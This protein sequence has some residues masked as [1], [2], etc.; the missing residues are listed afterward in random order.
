MRQ[1][2]TFAA[3]L[4]LA[5]AACTATT[6]APTPAPAAAA[7]TTP[8]AIIL[9][10]EWG[11]PHV[12]AEDEEALFFAYGWAQAHN[13]AEL[14]VE[15]LGRARARG[16]EVWGEEA[17]EDDVWYRTLGLPEWTRRSYA[18]LEPAMRRAVD[19]F[20]AGVNAYL[21]ENP[22]ALSPATAAVLPVSGEDVIA[23]LGA[24]R[25]RFSQARADAE[26]W[27]RRAEEGA[28]LP[29]AAE[30]ALASNAWALGPA[31]STSGNALLLANPHLPW[32][33]NL[34]W[35]EA[36]L[37][38]PGVDVYGA[39]LVGMPVIAIG[40]NRHL[41]WT[42]TV[43]TQDVED[44][45]RLDL[46]DGGY[47]FGGGVRPFERRVETVRVKTDDGFRDEEVEVLSSQHGPV[48]ATAGQEALALRRID[49]IADLGAALGQ[50]WAMGKAESFDDFAAALETH[51]IAGQNVTYADADGR[52]AY[53]YG[54]VL[55]RRPSGDADFWAGAVV[56]DEPELVWS[57]AHGFE[58][59]PRVIDPATGWLQN[60]NDPPWLST[61]PPALDP[62]DYPPYFAPRE[63]PLRPQQSIELLL[64]SGA[65][66]LEEMAALK[67][68]TEVEMAERVLPDLLAAVEAGEET[69][70]LVRRAAAVLAA[71]D[72]ST[73]PESRG[74][75]L[76]SAWV[77][78][79]FRRAGG[80]LFARPWDEAAP[81]ATPDGLADPAAAR[82][83]L[84]AA[85]AEVEKVHGA[86][87]VAWGEVNR[88]RVGDHDLPGNGGPGSLG[89][90]R[91][92]H[93][94][95]GD[96][97]TDVAVGGDSFVA[98]VEFA[99]AGPRALALLSYGNA[100][101]PASPH[102]GDQLRLYSERRLRPVR[103]TAAEVE[104]AAVERTELA[105]GEAP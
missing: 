20:A 105:V 31:K 55:P 48:V 82:D 6:P 5:A 14:L 100:S 39:S 42:H 91:V 16:A 32:G 24:I 46:V 40:F 73:E 80:D 50:W 15:N 76:F 18:A 47:R 61:F 36:H 87:D 34:T 52:I 26:R 86:L 25:L 60:A 97:T 104:A 29:Q 63:V 72:R 8:R 95:G 53:F 74:A 35:M 58:E 85:A 94:A 37:T 98:A 12:R 56:G 27:R 69:P 28:F 38:A 88:L 96:E 83:A 93:F 59:M 103:F 89:V 101:Q 23:N 90:F 62:E 43:N 78:E 44:L 30:R 102:R 57:A 17:L 99:A 67:H 81:L 64:E 79:M 68:S 65:L 11:I 13:H 10:D 84:A 54:G 2:L 41:G 3:A 70:E 1:R 51:A 92:T 9:W 7:E 49:D 33:G 21:A 22:E 4:A 45:Y 19:R 77:R 75:V 66:T 71:W